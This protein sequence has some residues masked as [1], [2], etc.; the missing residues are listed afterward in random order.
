M[1]HRFLRPLAAG[2]LLT[3]LAGN[4]LAQ[5]PEGTPAPDAAPQKAPA[6]PHS[7]NPHAGVGPSSFHQTPPPEDEL[8]EDDSPTGTLI[9]E[10]LNGLNQP[11]AEVVVELVVT[12]ETV[13]EGRQETVHR[14]TS[15][16]DGRVIFPNLKTGLHSS[17]AIVADYFGAVFHTKSFRMPEKNGL[18]AQVHVYPGVTN[19]EDTFVGMRNI[20]YVQL[21]ESAFHFEVLYR[22]FNMSRAAWV[23]KD[24][25]IVLPER[26]TGFTP[27]KAPQRFRVDEDGRRAYLEGTF[28]PGQTDLTLTFQIPS[29][30]EE[31]EVFRIGSLPHTADL[32]VITEKTKNLTM[33]VPGF[34]FTGSDVGPSG[35]P[36]LFARKSLGSAGREIGD[37]TIE[38]GGLPVTGPERWYAVFAAILVALGGLWGLKRRSADKTPGRVLSD[39]E[40]AQAE[41][42]RN[43]LLNE[44]QLLEKAKESELVGPR[45]Y[46]AT[47]KDLVDALARIALLLDPP[48]N[49]T[50]RSSG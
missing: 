35:A 3:T 46:E 18:R 36:V 40:R 5:A 34:D 7:Q 13:A 49:Q 10:T 22:I 25:F 44:L 21:R 38:L 9:V 30:N 48:Q 16:P 37:V 45:T 20:I 32:R 8:L 26:A 4:L 47:K 1:K 14:A 12:F 28:G 24:V 43:V 19:I 23:P 17:Y 6:N 31:R 50:S 11:V 39:E 27:S 15:G 2:L 33:T 41:E 42:A 29:R